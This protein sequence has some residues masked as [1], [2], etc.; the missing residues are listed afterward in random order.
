M[1]L[2]ELVERLRA[3]IDWAHF[4]SDEHMQDYQHE[5]IDAA[6]RIEALE[7]A[8]KPFATV[9]RIID[10]PFGPALFAEDE[11]AFKSGCAWTEN[12]ETKTLTWGD[13]RSALS[14]LQSDG[15]GS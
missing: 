6:D 8:L 7:T 13:F 3:P 14:A 1:T 5:R 11:M 10:G 2:S 12:G 15:E 9:G 4:V